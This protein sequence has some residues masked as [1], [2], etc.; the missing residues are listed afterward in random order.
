MQKITSEQ[1]E[2]S[3][4]RLSNTQ[5]GKVLLHAIMVHCKYHNNLM[6]SDPYETQFYAAKRGVYGWLRK[7]IECDSLMDIE[8]KFIIT[9]RKDPE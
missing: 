7:F 9:D 4:K 5:D 3:I 8:H 6:S 2:S 1:I